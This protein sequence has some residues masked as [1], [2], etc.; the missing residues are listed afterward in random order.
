MIEDF[1]GRRKLSGIRRY[2]TRRA[3]VPEVIASEPAAA[4]GPLLEQQ[5]RAYIEEAK[6][7]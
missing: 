6:R 3:A 5:V 1:D 7:K 2:P 4:V